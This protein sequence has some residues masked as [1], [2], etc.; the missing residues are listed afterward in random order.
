MKNLKT[1]LGILLVAVIA[2]SAA[3]TR[4]AVDAGY[5]VERRDGS[6][7]ICSTYTYGGL[8]T[9]DGADS[10]QIINNGSAAS[11]WEYILIADAL[12]GDSAANTVLQVIVDERDERD[13]LMSHTIVDTIAAAGDKVLLPFGQ[14]LFGDEYDIWLKSVN[15]DDETVVQGLWIVRRRPSNL[16]K[17]SS[18]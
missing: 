12:S 18:Y 2:Y 1:F 14:T 16:M 17:R 9:L 5:V 7:G 10:V 13:S 4:V 3:P 8:D 6:G 15:A 11:G